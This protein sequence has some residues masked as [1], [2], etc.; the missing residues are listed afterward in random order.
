LTSATGSGEFRRA[1]LGFAILKKMSE[2]FDL[3][4]PF[5][6][7]LPSA[8]ANRSLSDVKFS[9]LL[10][11][12]Y[13]ALSSTRSSVHDRTQAAKV[14]KILQARI[15]SGNRRVKQT[16]AIH[17]SNF[18]R[19][20]PGVSG[21]FSRCRSFERRRLHHARGVAPKTPQSW[22]IALTHRRVV[23]HFPRAHGYTNCSAQE[24]PEDKYD[25]QSINQAH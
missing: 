18:R 11:R 1:L 5:M 23:H 17:S 7:I 14:S 15:L 2:N 6:L 21:R 8:V 4:L 16:A 20:A 9:V 22:H 3:S 13:P 12:R 25:W 19:Q 10:I 24:K